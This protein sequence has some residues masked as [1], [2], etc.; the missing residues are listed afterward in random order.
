MWGTE[1]KKL[2]AGELTQTLANIGVIA[3]ILFLAFELRQN[4]E[5]LE[6]Q[7]R[8]AGNEQFIN[9]LA[10]QIQ[11]PSIIQLINADPETLS[12]LELGRFRTLGT[13]TF[14]EWEFQWG[15]WQRG[16]LDESAMDRRVRIWRNLFHPPPGGHNHLAD[17][18]DRYKQ[19]YATPEFIQWFEETIVNVK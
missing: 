15:E 19:I 6:Q 16:G 18:W 10:E 9:Q 1:L 7:S 3:G 17:N 5:L 14:A 4:N 2:S 12:P 8:F 11:D 13:R